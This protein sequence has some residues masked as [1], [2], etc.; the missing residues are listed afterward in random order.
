MCGIAEVCIKIFRHN[1]RG[2]E[3]RKIGQAG[4]PSKAGSFTSGQLLLHGVNLWCHVVK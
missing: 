4:V 3:L 1:L 2:R